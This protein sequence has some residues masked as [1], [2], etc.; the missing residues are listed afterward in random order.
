MCPLDG[1]DD[2]SQHLEWTEVK[3]EDLIWKFFFPISF[4]NA[5]G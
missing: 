4:L 5:V 3:E 2:L 1:S